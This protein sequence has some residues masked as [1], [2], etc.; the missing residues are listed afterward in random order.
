MQANGVLFTYV[1]GEDVRVAMK[2]APGTNQRRATPALR[3]GSRIRLTQPSTLWMLR[4]ERSC[5][6]AA[7][8][9]PHGIISAESPARTAGFIFPRSTGCSTALELP[10]EGLAI[11][12]CGYG[13]SGCVGWRSPGSDG[14]AAHAGMVDK[15]CRCAKIFV[16]PARRADLE[17]RNG[18]GQVWLPVE[19]QSE[20]PAQ[21]IELSQPARAGAQCNG[22]QRLPVARLC[23]R[24]LRIPFLP[25]TTTSP[26][27]IGKSTL[28]Q[29]FR[30]RQPGHVRAE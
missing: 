23:W 13:F 18:D 4:P 16:D 25:W 8:R 21:T 30:H 17:E 1:S 6:R 29:R 19:A 28:T 14:R 22:S 2:T 27:C 10:S 7:I 9:S 20:Q 26:C 12:G 11:Q 5:G 24:A 3:A 15:R